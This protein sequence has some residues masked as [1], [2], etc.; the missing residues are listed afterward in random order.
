M[1]PIKQNSKT[2]QSYHH[3]DIDKHLNPHQKTIHVKQNKTIKK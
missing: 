1:N 2:R 3:D